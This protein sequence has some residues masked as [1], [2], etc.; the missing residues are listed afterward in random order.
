MGHDQPLFRRFRDRGARR[1]STRVGAASG[2]E[3]RHRSGRRAGG[4]RPRHPADSR[5][6]LL[7]VPRR[8]ENEGQAAS[9]PACRR[10]EGRRN[11][12]RDRPGR[13][14]AQPDGSAA[15]RPRR[16]RPDAEGRRSGAR[17]SDRVD[18]G[19]D[20]SR[21]RVA[22]NGCRQCRRGTAGGAG[23]AR[24]LG[25]SPARAC[26]A[27][28]GPPGRL[29]ADAD[30][31][32]HPRAARERRAEAVA[33]SAA[34]DARPP[35]LARSDRVAAFAA[36]GGR[37][38]RRCRA[39]R[40]GRSLRAA[41][42]QAPRV[43]ALR[44]AVGAAVARPRALR[45]FA[46]VREGSAARHVEVP[47]LGDRRAQSGHAVRSLH[48]RA[49]C[50]RHAAERDAGAAGRERISSQRDDQRRR[51]DRSG[52]SALRGPRRSG[53]HDRDRLARQHARLR[54]VPQP[55]V[56]TRSARRTTTG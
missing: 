39:R 29:G 13:Q 48:H 56:P 40:T 24:A 12:R 17:R 21:G 38:A 14:R 30:R 11:R 22:G 15:A 49:D 54:A 53:Q 33:A 37:G 9:R 41:G 3:T 19:L 55:Q 18:S 31:P 47:R 2:A 46:W 34:G 8:E 23:R 26:H 28:R 50:R 10:D 42:G 4:L 6:P 5:D 32:F 45:R 7:R 16:R 52:R 20:R 27:S 1:A 25:L 36:G 43:A 44:R 35:R 51:R